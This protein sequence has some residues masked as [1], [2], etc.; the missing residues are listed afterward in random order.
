MASKLK[1]LVPP[2]PSQP[3]VRLDLRGG[4]SLDFTVYVDPDDHKKEYLICDLCGRQIRL[5]VGRSPTHLDQHRDKG[6]CKSTQK[7][8]AKKRGLEDE[9][10]RAETA[11]AFLRQSQM[12]MCVQQSGFITNSHKF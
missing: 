1:E 7:T 9:R 6:A 12:G 3:P 2:T 10:K 4:G 11:L 5:P 8:N